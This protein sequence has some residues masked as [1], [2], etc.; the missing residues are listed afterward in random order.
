[1][2]WLCM[3]FRCS[4]CLVVFGRVLGLVY[5]GL[6]DVMVLLVCRWVCVS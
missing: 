2:L 5:S 3:V 6:V 1:M 4:G